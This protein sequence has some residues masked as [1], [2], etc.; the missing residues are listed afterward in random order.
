MNPPPEFSAR[1][2]FFFLNL[3]KGLIH[4]HVFDKI[5]H[6]KKKN[7]IQSLNSFISSVGGP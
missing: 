1:K 7:G 4:M 2:Y 6:S 5:T 3:P